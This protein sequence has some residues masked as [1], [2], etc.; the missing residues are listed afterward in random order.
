MQNSSEK[1]G[2]VNV[3]TDDGGSKTA[4]RAEPANPREH[5]NF[6]F[7]APTPVARGE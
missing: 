3:S 7:R 5:T 1:N 4:L 2:E 6:P